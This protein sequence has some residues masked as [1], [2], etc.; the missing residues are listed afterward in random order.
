MEL[1]KEDIKHIECVGKCKK[2]DV[3]HILTKGGHNMIVVKSVGGAYHI[4]GTGA[5]RAFA[6]HQAE[7]VEKNIEWDETLNK[8]EDFQKA[9]AM[10]QASLLIKADHP[11]DSMG[12]P[13]YESTPQNHYDLAVYHSKLAGKYQAQEVP[14]DDFNARMDRD[15]RRMYHTDTALKHYQASGLEYKA[16]TEEHKKQMQYHTELKPGE[17]A[18]FQDYPLQLAWQRKNKGKRFPKGLPYDWKA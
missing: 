11:R 3:Y 4:L 8:S 17:G 6:I 12:D 14:K 10:N 5:H 13:I 18:P 1:T 15:M 7:Q 9:Q 2:G 16:S